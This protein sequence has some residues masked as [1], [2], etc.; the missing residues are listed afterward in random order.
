MRHLEYRKLN[1]IEP[2]KLLSLLNKKT[3]RQHLV[4]HAPF[5]PESIAE[6]INSKVDTDFR[7][8]CRVRAITID[9]QLAGWCGI[10]LEGQNYEIAIVIEDIYWG[11]GRPVFFEMMSWA[12]ELGHTI[13]H[14]HL[15]NTRPEYNF[16]KK[17]AKKVYQSDIL[18]GKFTTYE[19]EVGQGGLK[20]G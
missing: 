1:E 12:K 15:L 8:G 17:I 3:T 11:L 2:K 5:N 13:I 6:W 9:K 16:L 19:I 20:V 14:I 7:H 4:D 18:G 10:Q